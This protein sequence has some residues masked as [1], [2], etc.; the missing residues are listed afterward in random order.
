MFSS[1]LESNTLRPFPPM[2]KLSSIPTTLTVMIP[3]AFAVE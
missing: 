1:S 3:L 2:D